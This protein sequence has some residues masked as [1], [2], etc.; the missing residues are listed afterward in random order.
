MTESFDWHKPIGDEEY[1]VKIK[2]AY[3]DYINLD[4]SVDRCKEVDKIKNL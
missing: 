3:K 2:Q 4:K 1:D